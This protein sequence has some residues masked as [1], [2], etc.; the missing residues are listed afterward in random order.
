MTQAEQT[1]AAH[2]AREGD[3]MQTATGRQFWPIDPRPEEVCIEDIAHALSMLCR[4]GGHCR[5]FYS[6][7]EHSVLLS[8]SVAPEHALWALMHD[9]SEAYL[10]DVPRPI[11]P[12]LMGYREAEDRIM[13]A[14]CERFDMPVDM[15]AEVK[16]ADGR[17]LADEAAQNM[18][19]PP[20]TWN[21]TGAPLG[22]ELQFWTPERARHELLSRFCDLTGIAAQPE[23]TAVDVRVP[24]EPMETAPKDGTPIL[25]FFGE[26][27]RTAGW[28]TGDAEYPWAFIDTGM[29]DIGTGVNHSRDDKYGPS[30]W[31]PFKCLAT[32]PAETGEV[33]AVRWPNGC[34][35]TV[36][37]ALRFLANNDRPSGGEQ[38]FNRAHLYQLAGEIERMAKSPLYAHP[39]VSSADAATIERK[40]LEEATFMRNAAVKSRQRAETAEA[41]AADLRRQLAESNARVE[42]RCLEEYEA[43]ALSVGVSNSAR[44]QRIA[45][46]R[47][48]LST[49]GGSDAA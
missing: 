12:S 28:W 15:P 39:P 44:T 35:E 25:L 18:E 22:V 20:V 41:E 38:S 32:T 13:S 23:P 27:T 3:W 33:E 31:A 14:V 26:D 21:D 1:H 48:T 5:R 24:L 43:F 8:R 11:K 46:L 42:L 45:K 37:E 10:V 40:A 2:T 17:I 19:V 36:P 34:N 9:A 6:V 4:F 7:A 29:V 30:H 49:E 16:H 47:A